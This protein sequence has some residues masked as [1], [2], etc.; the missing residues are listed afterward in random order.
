MT[1]Q[2]SFVVGCAIPQDGNPAGAAERESRPVHR[3]GGVI[4]WPTF[5][6]YKTDYELDRPPFGVAEGWDH[7]VHVTRQRDAIR[8][9]ATP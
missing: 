3:P 7:M 4:H 5:E 1:R 2:L 9:K 6:R 8:R